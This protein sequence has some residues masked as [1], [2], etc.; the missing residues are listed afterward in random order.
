MTAGQQHTCALADDGVAYCW[1]YNNQAELG[2]NP[3]R[4]GGDE[5]LHSLVPVAVAGGLTFR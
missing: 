1:G 3:Q 4:G 5:V 2:N